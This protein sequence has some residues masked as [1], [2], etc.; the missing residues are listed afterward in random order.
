MGTMVSK[1]PMHS[2]NSISLYL[3]PDAPTIVMA[4]LD[5]KTKTAYYRVWGRFK[6]FCKDYGLSS[7]L[8][9]SVILLLNFLTSL[10]QLGHQL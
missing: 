3:T 4:Y 5:H 1:G 2:A 7:Q 8:P 9:I 10:F 6:T